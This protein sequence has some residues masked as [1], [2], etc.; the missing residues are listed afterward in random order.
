LGAGAIPMGAIG[1]FRS[2]I[3]PVGFGEMKAVGVPGIDSAAAHGIVQPMSFALLS[4][5]FVSVFSVL[6]TFIALTSFSLA[7]TSV[8]NWK[9]L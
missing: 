6:A 4:S 8:A 1:I 2:F 5:F 3:T 7:S 9:G